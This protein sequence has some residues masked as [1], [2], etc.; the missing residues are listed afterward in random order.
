MEEDK[1]LANYFLSYLKRGKY[2]IPSMNKYLDVSASVFG[3][4]KSGAKIKL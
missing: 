1:F 2:R 4:H 3:F